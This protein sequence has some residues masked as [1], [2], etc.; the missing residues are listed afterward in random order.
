MD[1]VG[2]FH[3]DLLM[4]THTTIII[5]CLLESWVYLIISSF[6][7][8]FERSSGLRSDFILGVL[9]K[10]KLEFVK[11]FHFNLFMKDLLDFYI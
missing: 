6:R 1:D 5:I 10:F 2:L 11:L 7:H 3:I 9:F 8:L 4:S